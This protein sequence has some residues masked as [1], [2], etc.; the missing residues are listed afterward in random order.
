MGHFCPPGSESGST[1]LIESGSDPDPAPCPLPHHSTHLPDKGLDEAVDSEKDLIGVLLRPTLRDR[2][3]GSV[4]IARVGHDLM[5]PAIIVVVVTPS[6]TVV[7]IVVERKVTT[8]TTTS[9]HCMTPN[10]STG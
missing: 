2:E 10:S 9:Y 8:T 4:Y 6:A 1:D 5:M 3:D 7:I